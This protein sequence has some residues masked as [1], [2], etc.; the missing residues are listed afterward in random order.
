MIKYKKGSRWIVIDDAGKMHS[1]FKEEDA[2][3]FAGESNG[4]KEGSTA[5]AGWSEGVQQTKAYTKSP[6]KKSYSSG[7]SWDKN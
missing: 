4:K 2:S 7:K 5:K 1:F 6:E 3:S